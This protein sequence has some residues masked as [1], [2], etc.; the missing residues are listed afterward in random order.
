MTSRELEASASSDLCLEEREAFGRQRRGIIS[1]AV[2]RLPHTLVR[3][4]LDWTQD[5]I[6]HHCCPFRGPSIP[7][8]RDLAAPDQDVELAEHCL[9]SLI[10]E[11]GDADSTVGGLEHT[12]GRRPMLLDRAPQF[13]N[14]RQHPF[15]RQLI[16]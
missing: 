1:T 15:G 16:E 14:A 8:S 2:S 7:S 13:S 12:S 11:P 6:G 4:R 3:R 10:R 5:E 9:V